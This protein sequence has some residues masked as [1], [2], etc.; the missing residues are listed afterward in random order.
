MVSRVLRL[1]SSL[2]YTRPVIRDSSIAHA[3]FLRS[4]IVDIREGQPT[5]LLLAFWESQAP[6]LGYHHRSA[7]NGFLLSQW[8]LLHHGCLLR[9]VER[10]VSHQNPTKPNVLRPQAIFPPGAGAQVGIATRDGSSVLR[11]LLVT[12]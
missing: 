6:D 8:S 3:R 12:F 9:P 10:Y 5:R 2:T 7:W 4:H 1:C 11:M